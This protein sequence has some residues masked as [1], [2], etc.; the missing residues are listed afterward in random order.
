MNSINV[1]SLMNRQVGQTQSKLSSEAGL[2][3]HDGVAHSEPVADLAHQQ[4]IPNEASPAIL[5]LAALGCA[6]VT[7][8]LA[9][10]V[11]DL[12]TRHKTTTLDLLWGFLAGCPFACGRRSLVG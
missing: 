6:A 5:L 11:P 3:S 9:C 10:D 12:R 2:G 7:A 4:S 8:L 1:H